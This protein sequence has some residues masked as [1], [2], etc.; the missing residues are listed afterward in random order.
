MRYGPNTLDLPS[1]QAWLRARLAAR[2]QPPTLLEIDP[3]A[4]FAPEQ[5]E[6]RLA[7]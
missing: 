2:W 3:L 4:R 1:L 6:Q 5:V 7:Q